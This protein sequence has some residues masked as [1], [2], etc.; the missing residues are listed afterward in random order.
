MDMCFHVDKGKDKRDEGSVRFSIKS[1]ETQLA[2]NITSD[3]F[4]D[5]LLP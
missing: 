4:L 5:Q 2:P 3:G 1:R